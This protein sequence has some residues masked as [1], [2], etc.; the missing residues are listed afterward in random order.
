[1]DMICHQTVGVQSTLRLTQ[2]TTQVKQIKASILVL[3]EA[4][5]AIVASVPD[6]HRDT[7][8]HEAGASRH[9]A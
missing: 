9:N 1:M 2:Q 4:S 7:G 8:K 3:K 5:L 6:V